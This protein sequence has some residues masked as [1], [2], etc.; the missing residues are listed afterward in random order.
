MSFIRR[1]SIDKKKSDKL[2]NNLSTL[3]STLLA[4]SADIST[5]Q[6]SIVNHS[7]LI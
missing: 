4:Q 5:S 1:N 6:K 7:E 3:N 2:Q